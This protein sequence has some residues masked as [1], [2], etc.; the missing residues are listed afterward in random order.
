M[1]NN[2]FIVRSPLQIIN[3]LEAIEYFSLKNNILV[4]V[5]N[6]T[7]NTNEQMDK[8]SSLY[9]WKEIIYVNKEK[10]KSKFYE[11]IGLIKKLREKP[12]NYVF[13]SNYGSVQRIILANL[14]INELYF[15]DDGVE[16]LNRYDEIFV[17][18]KINKF[19][20]K[21]ARF[22]IFGLKTKIKN[23]INFFTY[24]DLEAFGDSLVIKNNLEYFHKEYF[25]NMKEDNITYILGQPLI[26]SK[27]V[28]ENDYLKYIDFLIKKNKKVVYIPHRA[29][30]ISNSLASYE[31]DNFEIRYINM[32]IEL[33]FLEKKIYPYAIISFLTTAFF[34]LDKLYNKTKLSYVYIPKENILQKHKDV[35]NVYNTISNLNI[36]KIE[37]N[38]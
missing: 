22:W 3:A 21:L 12:Y 31:N 18:N 24:F 5:Y 34:T 4:I 17:K 38:G 28:S 1:H 33:Y 37:F 7:N 30:K 19:R 2:L 23:T 35:E 20:L 10:K 13:F 36:E 27:L 6:N 29:E 9:E 16:T 25:T 8:I 15:I 14:K 11:Y 26:E 32:P